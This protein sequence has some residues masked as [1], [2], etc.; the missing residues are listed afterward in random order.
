MPEHCPTCK[1]LLEFE[2]C[3]NLDCDEGD[4]MSD[5]LGLR[6]C[7]SCG[8]AGGAWFCP[9]GCDRYEDDYTPPASQGAQDA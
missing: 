3:E 5:C 4:D 1:A 7:W 8:G 2:I 6:K 9:N